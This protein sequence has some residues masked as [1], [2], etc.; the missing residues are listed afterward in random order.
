LVLLGQQVSW[1]FL[2]RVQ[3]GLVG[4]LMTMLLP[5]LPLLQTVLPHQTMPPGQHHLL[6]LLLVLLEWCWQASAVDS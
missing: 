6:R 5:L 3:W 1:W 4:V 2:K